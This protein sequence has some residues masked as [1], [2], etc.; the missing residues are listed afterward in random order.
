MLFAG[1]SLT[2]LDVTT[3]SGLTLLNIRY[4]N[5]TSL[6]LSENHVINTVEL[7]ANGLIFLDLRNGNQ[8]NMVYFDS[9]DNPNL[10]CILF[11]DGS[12]IDRDNH[13]VWFIDDLTPCL[14][15]N[16][17]ECSSCL[18]TLSIDNTDEVAFNMY[19]NPAEGSLHVT[20]K[21]DHAMFSICSITGKIILTKDLH[22]DDNIIDVSALASG[23]YITRLVSN[24]QTETKKLLIK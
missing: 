22:L 12:V 8:A 14:V 16:E 2:S 21:V 7:K 20:T 11:D 18:N 19:P 3:N 13:V 24:N 6:D 4:N 9:D 15:S 10:S 23:L 5:V 17:A 1:A